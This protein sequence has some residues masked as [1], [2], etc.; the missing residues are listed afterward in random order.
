MPQHR[1]EM[2]HKSRCYISPLLGLKDLPEKSERA[3]IRVDGSFTTPQ[4]CPCPTWL[5]RNTSTSRIR[6]I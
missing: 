5:G 4:V 3:H 6:F 1:F 2:M